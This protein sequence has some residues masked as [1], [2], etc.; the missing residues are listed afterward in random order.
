MVS[1]FLKVFILELVAVHQTVNKKN[2][3]I[4]ERK[5]RNALIL[6]SLKTLSEW[7]IIVTHNKTSM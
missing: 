3:Q 2:M 7:Q 6:V 4:K 5:W 1:V